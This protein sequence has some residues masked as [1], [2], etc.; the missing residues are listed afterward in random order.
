MSYIRVGNRGP[1]YSTAPPYKAWG[2]SPVDDSN[3]SDFPNE[4]ESFNATYAK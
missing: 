1:P 3:G 2:K 4:N